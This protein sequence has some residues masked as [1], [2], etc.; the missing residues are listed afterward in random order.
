MALKDQIQQDTKDALRS[1]DKD[2]LSVLRMALAAIKQREVDE[3][4]DMA[5]PEITAIIEKMVKQR[6]ESV[7]QYEAGG[8][9]DLADKE[10]AEIEILRTYLPE[11]M[12][13]AEL[14]DLVAELVAETGAASVKD[15][16]RVMGLLKQRAQGRVDMGAASARVR[17]AL[18]A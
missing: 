10:A 12:T 4:A 1:G 3:R 15:M 7:A 8:R 14:E 16:G 5:D 2:R 9:Q 11:P 18:G 6:R 13:D 17:A